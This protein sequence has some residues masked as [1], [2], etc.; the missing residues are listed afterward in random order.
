MPEAKPAGRG[1][2]LAKAVAV[3]APEA[4][5]SPSRLA[6]Q[7]THRKRPARTGQDEGATALH[8]APPAVQTVTPAP[9]SAREPTAVH[10][11]RHRAD[12]DRPFRP[13]TSPGKRS[14]RGSGPGQPYAPR[15]A[16][17]SVPLSARLP[18]A[19][20]RAACHQPRRA[21]LQRPHQPGGVDQR[22]SPRGG[23]R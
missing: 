5:P 18:I 8:G 14:H 15:T 7:R 16:R 17:A 3:Q 20:D 22:G 23:A 10:H 6:H 12:H 13:R 11:H 19:S 1:R 4:K 2:K 21:S 9:A